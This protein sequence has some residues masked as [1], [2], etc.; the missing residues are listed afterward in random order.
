MIYNFY[1]NISYNKN[2]YANMLDIESLTIYEST[3]IT[4][5]Y[6]VII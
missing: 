3:Q 6:I 2:G 1:I 4:Y 5:Y